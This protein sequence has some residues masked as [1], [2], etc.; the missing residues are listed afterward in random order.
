MRTIEA[1]TD[2]ISPAT[3]STDTSGMRGRR[4]L[5][6]VLLGGAIL[7]LGACTMPVG[8]STTPNAGISPNTL[9]QLSVLAAPYQN[10]QS[11]ELREDGCYWY[12]HDGPVEDT[13][14]PLRTSEGRFICKV[15]PD[16]TAG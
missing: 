14:L 11:V 5:K 15:D 9:E 4:I 3:P 8:G 10:L 7:T 12:R 2:A 13:M 6:P 16:Q 1:N